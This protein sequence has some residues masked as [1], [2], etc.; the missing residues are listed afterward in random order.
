MDIKLDDKNILDS[1]EDV[2]LFLSEEDTTSITKKSKSELHRIVHNNISLSSFKGKLSD[3]LVVPVESEPFRRVVLC[4]IG[5]KSKVDLESLRRAA[6]NGLRTASDLKQDSISIIPPRLKFPKTEIVRALS[7]GFRLS[8]YEFDK[9]I[10]EKNSKFFHIKSISIYVDKTDRTLEEVLEYSKITCDATYLARDLQSDDADIV[11]PE[12]LVKVAK[13]IAKSQKLKIKVLSKPKLLR[14]GLN[15]IL[16]VG[17]GS[18]FDP[19]LIILEYN[20]NPKSKEKT[21]IVGK[22]ITYDTGGLDIKPRMMSEMNIDMSGSAVVLATMKAVSEL[23]L[24]KNIIM[25]APVCEN[26]VGSLAQ[27]PGAV[28]KSY[29]GKT[30]EVENTDAEG[31]LILADAISYV[32]KKYKPTQIIDFATLTGSIIVA[33]GYKYAGLFSTDRAANKIITAAAK[34]GE[35]VWRMP[36]PEDYAKFLKSKKADLRN[37][38]TYPNH[39]AGSITA[40]LFLKEFTEDIPWTHIDIAGTSRLNKRDFYNPPFGTGF[41][42]RLLCDFFSQK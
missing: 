42:P 35:L 5:K 41:G 25:V 36:L 1:K 14:E 3:V 9:Y 31:R 18:R 33:L 12:Y 4:G 27:K 37:V 22:G 24:K 30:V 32:I 13:D 10:T 15:M 8:N 7:D 17:Q 26:A 6:H 38:S 20:G 34:T 16:G 40:A 2:M 39:Y 29:S 19:Y 21:A 11:N 28:L 23:K